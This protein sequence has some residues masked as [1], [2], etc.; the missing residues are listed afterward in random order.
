VLTHPAFQLT[1]A[2]D[3]PKAEGLSCTA[4]KGERCPV[5]PPRAI[6]KSYFF[7]NLTNINSFLKRF[8]EV[9]ISW[10]SPMSALRAATLKDVG[11][12][13]GDLWSARHFRGGEYP[14]APFGRHCGTALDDEWPY[15][16]PMISAA[17]RGGDAHP[18]LQI[19]G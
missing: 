12:L 9:V 8:R 7:E 1:V 18:A 10:S 6:S 11:K 13:F 5:Y 2:P 3:I 16:T 4:P 15:A 17:D 19:K 14:A